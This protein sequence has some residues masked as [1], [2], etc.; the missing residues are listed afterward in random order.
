MEILMKKILPLLAVLTFVPFVTSAETTLALITV[1]GSGA[2]PTPPDLAKLNMT[3]GSRE[4]A[5]SKAKTDVDSKVTQLTAVLQK[6]GVKTA[7]INNAPLRIY[8]EYQPEKNTAEL[9]RVERELTVTVRDL[10]LYPEILE[11]AAVLGVTQL[12][13]AELLSSK[14]EG[15]YQQALKLAYADAEQKA[16]ALAKLSGRK[17]ARVHQI[18]EQ[19]SSPTPRLK[20]EMMA[21]DSVQFGSNNIRAD[22]TIQFELA[23][24]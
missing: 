18:Q 9:F 7:D 2:V 3:I 12:H 1:Q 5:V 4:A 19:G 24:P 11:Q 14:A 17:I 15:L 21:A 8:P 22:L 23:N 6:L 20:M 10:A 16:K 13:P